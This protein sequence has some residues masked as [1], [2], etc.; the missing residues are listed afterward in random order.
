MTESERQ[1]LFDPEREYLN[2]GI[3][4]GGVER[5]VISVP[6]EQTSNAFNMKTPNVYISPEDL[7]DVEI[8]ERIRSLNLLGLYIFTP[9]D[10]YSFISKLTTLW[11]LNIR[12]AQNLKSLDFLKDLPEI[13]MLMLYGAEL[14][15]VDVIFDMKRESKSFLYPFRCV[16]FYDCKIEKT[17]KFQDQSR[18]FGEFIVWQRPERDERERWRSVPAGKNKYYVIEPKEG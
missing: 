12:Q 11:D 3:T 7:L 10:D 5:G 15:N 1:K 14:D 8:F 17:P 16:G 6:W 2:L 9:L 4:E 13:R 18:S